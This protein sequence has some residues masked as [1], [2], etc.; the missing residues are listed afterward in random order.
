M[1][2]FWSLTIGAGSGHRRLDYSLWRVARISG[3]Y[4]GCRPALNSACVADRL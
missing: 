4:S 2:L 1:R 3:L